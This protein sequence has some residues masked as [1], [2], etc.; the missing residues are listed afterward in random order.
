MSQKI[1]KDIDNHNTKPIQI[2]FDRDD[3][4]TFT[5]AYVATYYFYR[6]N[7]AKAVLVVSY[8]SLL[9]RLSNWMQFNSVKPTKA[10]LI[11]VANERR[12]K[13]INFESNENSHL[14]GYLKQ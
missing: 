14:K 2:H 6:L 5:Y 8:E 3:P 4:R 13:Q 9:Q 1:N 12:G 11:S 7:Y 10:T